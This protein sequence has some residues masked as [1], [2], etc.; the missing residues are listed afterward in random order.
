LRRW[1]TSRRPGQHP[2]SRQP[3][4]P[5]AS[6]RTAR[7]AAAWLAASTASSPTAAAGQLVRWRRRTSDASMWRNG[8]PVASLAPVPH[9]L[10][11]QRSWSRSPVS[12]SARTPCSCTVPAS[13]PRLLKPAE[14]RSHRLRHE[15]LGL[16]HV[17][18]M[19]LRHLVT[20]SA[21]V[22]LVRVRCACSLMRRRPQCDPSAPETLPV[23]TG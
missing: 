4:W 21:Q 7:G 5:G 15:A 2:I 12:A 11:R 22:R 9:N 3:A 18:A 10:R 13:T 6:R 1:A 17:K 19:P 8:S 14:P 23:V 16:R 20:S